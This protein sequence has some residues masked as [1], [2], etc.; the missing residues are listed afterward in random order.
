MALKFQGSLR[1]LHT[2]IGLVLVALFFIPLCRGDEILR[3]NGFDGYEA[4]EEA[5][6]SKDTESVVWAAEKVCNLGPKAAPF[7]DN[8]LSALNFFHANNDTKVV[9]KLVMALAAIGPAAKKS[10][11]QLERLLSEEQLQRQVTIALVKIASCTIELP[12]CPDPFGEPVFSFL[13]NRSS[14]RVFYSQEVPDTALKRNSTGFSSYILRGLP[15]QIELKDPLSIGNNFSLNFWW[16]ASNLS[17]NSALNLLSSDLV[18]FKLSKSEY[19][20]KTNLDI[21]FRLPSAEKDNAEIE[22]REVDLFKPNIATMGSFGNSSF[23]SEDQWN[24][25]ILVRNGSQHSIK[26]YLNGDKVATCDDFTVWSGR[27][28]SLITCFPK[29]ILKSMVFGGKPYDDHLKFD[30][31][32]QIEL[33]TIEFYNCSLSEAAAKEKFAMQKLTYFSGK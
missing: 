1:P 24:N 7:V 3:K 5:F 26:I 32:G 12:D 11:S 29:T 28:R 13:G 17:S 21:A 15:L 23:L 4:I 22:N 14:E 25:I 16:K 2:F 31:N 18:Q 8:I 27:D 19:A 20:H 33:S 9:F 30:S 6:N 10:V